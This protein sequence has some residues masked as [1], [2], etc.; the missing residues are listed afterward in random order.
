MNIYYID[1]FTDKIFHGNT[2]AVVPLQEWLPEERMQ[3]MAAQHKLSETV[4][5]VPRGD[6]FDIRWFTPEAEVD[7]CG[8]ATMASAYVIWN[9]LGHPVS[10]II[11]HSKSGALKV[12][13]NNGNITLDFP[14]DYYLDQ[15]APDK[16]IQALGKKPKEAYIGK[17]NHLLVYEQE[18]DIKRMDPDFAQ[19][20]EVKTHG[21]IVTAKG[22]DVDYVYRFFA[23]SIGVNEDP[24]TGS[25]QTT[26]TN[27]WS[28]KID[29][30]SWTS[31]QLS[32]RMGHFRT[33]IEGDRV[34]IT[35]QAVPYMTGEI[36]LP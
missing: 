2:A 13:K 18:E 20:K 22:Y 4:F 6:A 15:E 31:I 12:T 16:M 10:Y 9:M 5:F 19:L 29:K 21:V 14:I 28:K 23:P 36:L 7:L 34:L 17:H 27:Y 8:H 32:K 35:G 11:F 30:E 3:E 24:A 33:A 25:V 26:L 1:V